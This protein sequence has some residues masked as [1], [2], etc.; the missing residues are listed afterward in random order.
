MDNFNPR[1]PC[2]VR[3]VPCNSQANISV[4]SI[5]APRVGCDKWS[6]LIREEEAISIHAPRV[7]CDRLSC[8]C[9]GFR[10]YFNPRTPCGVRLF[11]GGSLSEVVRISIHAPRVGCDTHTFRPGIRWFDFNPRTP[12]GVRL[13]PFR[14][15]VPCCY[16]NPRTP[17]GVRPD[18]SRISRHGAHFNPRTPCGVRRF[19]LGGFRCISVFQS[20]H[21]VWGA[22][23][24]R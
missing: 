3:Q 8:T 24:V 2:G 13:C 11:P 15:A 5:H 16:F 19:R 12:C 14:G 22:T 21:P 4:I 7:G 1:T 6:A 18:S 10:P 20:T 23:V 9:R 17:C